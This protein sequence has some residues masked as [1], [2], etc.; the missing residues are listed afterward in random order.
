MKK[1]P[2]RWGHADGEIIEYGMSDCVRRCSRCGRP[3]MML[4]DSISPVRVFAALMLVAIT[5]GI[6]IGI[7]YRVAGKPDLL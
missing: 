6:I 3:Y 5:L 4:G 7:I 2:C 1:D